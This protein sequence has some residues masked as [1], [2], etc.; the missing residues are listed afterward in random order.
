MMLWACPQAEKAWGRAFGFIFF[1]KKTRKRI[2]PQSLTQSNFNRQH[3]LFKIQLFTSV[4][5]QNIN[6]YLLRNL[7][8]PFCPY[9]CKNYL[10]KYLQGQ[11]RPNRI[12]TYKEL[13]I[14]RT[15]SNTNFMS[16]YTRNR[17]VRL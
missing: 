9:I 2:P 1:W 3:A 10:K 14:F 12:E 5:L 6:K 16:L 13:A 7:A 17:N 8:K 15:I 11:K 4:L